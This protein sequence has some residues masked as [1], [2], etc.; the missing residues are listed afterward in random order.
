MSENF[1]HEI[2]VG[3]GHCDPAQI[4][5]TGHLPSFALEAIDAW[6]GHH[7]GG[8]GWYHL[9]LDRGV[10]TPFVSM[11]LDFRSPVTPRHSL[12]CEVWPSRLGTSSIEFKVKARQNGGLC[13]E[14]SFVS[15]FIT[16]GMFKSRPA[17]EDIRA[18]VEPLLRD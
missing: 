11:N 12:E 3:W 4:A 18:L 15:V 14:G 17:P 13:F 8:S 5:Y 9:E 2:R 10:G 6:W 16:P 7:F 1:V